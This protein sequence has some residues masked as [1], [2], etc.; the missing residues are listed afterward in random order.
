MRFGLSLC[1]IS[2]DAVFFLHGCVTYLLE[3]QCDNYL[4]LLPFAAGI[5]GYV[6]EE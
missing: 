3:C 6:I 5:D 2:N 4:C 1:S